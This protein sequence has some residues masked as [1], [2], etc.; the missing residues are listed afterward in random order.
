[1]KLVRTL[2][3]AALLVPALP[4]A[5]AEDDPAFGHMLSLM[6]VF[7]RLA[8]QSGDPV[9]GLKAMDDV[10]AGRNAD[11]NQ[12]AFG[13]FNEMTAGMPA[14]HKSKVASIAGD[15]LGLARRD[16]GQAQLQGQTR[17]SAPRQMVSTD[18]SLQARKDLTG[19]GL[20]YY[21]A[22]DYLDAVKRDDALAVELFVAGRGVNL[23]S[24]DADGR[25]APEIARANGNAQLAE[26]LSRSLPA[27]R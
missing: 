26:L 20:R 27:A 4:A 24:R 8:A 22:K 12:A 5:A 6:Q 9:A 16:L 13:L 17:G 23:A 21:D 2:L 18:T 15:V 14:E 10:L 11:A 1:M 25:S 3:L 7:V 19:M